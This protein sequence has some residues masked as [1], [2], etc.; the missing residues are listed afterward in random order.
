MHTASCLKV[1][2]WWAVYLEVIVDQQAPVEAVHHGLHAEHWLALNLLPLV[3]G[4]RGAAL[5]EFGGP[6]CLSPRKLLEPHLYNEEK[7]R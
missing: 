7:Q 4:Q 3:E 1:G 2:G 6:L 5:L